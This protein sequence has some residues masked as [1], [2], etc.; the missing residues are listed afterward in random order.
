M[1]TENDTWKGRTDGIY[2]RVN[3]ED[4]LA[5][6]SKD[7][8]PR[9]KCPRCDLSCNGGRGC[10]SPKLAFPTCKALRMY[11][12]RKLEPSY[13]VAESDKCRPM[14]TFIDY[15]PIAAGRQTTT[16]NSICTIEFNP[17]KSTPK[18]EA[19]EKER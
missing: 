17:K 15:E 6:K 16:A 5:V 12:F 11:L 13:A 9:W 3:G 8:S 19:N 14:V 7:P 2:L 1:K 10:S 18:G 4:Y